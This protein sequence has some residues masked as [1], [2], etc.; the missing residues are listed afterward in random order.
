MQTDIIQFTWDKTASAMVPV[1]RYRSMCERLFE[2]GH[3][4]RM[5]V[6]EERSMRS[7]RFYFAALHEAWLNLNEKSAAQF[8]TPEHLRHWALVQTG[9]CTERDF[10]LDSA[11]EATRL[12]TYFRKVSSYSVIKVSA[13]VVKVFEPE[14]QSI[15]AMKKDR[16]EASKRD[17]LDLAATMARTTQTK[18]M[19]QVG[20]A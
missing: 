15:K 18:L 13:N 19:A 7:H 20:K 16:F 4:Y 14:S 17:V 3:H 11:K 5:E 1:G 8:P 2:D 9:Y 6:H 12:A 10:V